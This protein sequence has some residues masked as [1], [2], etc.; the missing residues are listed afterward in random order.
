MDKRE[1]TA[2]TRYNRADQKYGY[3]INELINL[4]KEKGIDP[5]I[6]ARPTWANASDEVKE[7]FYKYADAVIEQGGGQSISEEKS[8]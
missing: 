7:P 3:V 4:L 8:E 2:M 6:P 1:K 5:S